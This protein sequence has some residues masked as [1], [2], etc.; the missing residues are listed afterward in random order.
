MVRKTEVEWN[1]RNFVVLIAIGTQGTRL[2]FLE[3]NDFTI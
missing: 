3:P 1:T 2:W